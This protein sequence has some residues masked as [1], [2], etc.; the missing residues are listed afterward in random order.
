MV[1][2]WVYW[3][4][5]P[6]LGEWSLI[7][8]WYFLIL[9]VGL[10]R[11]TVWIPRLDDRPAI[12]LLWQ[13]CEL[14]TFP[15]AS[16]NQRQ[17][18]RNH[19]YSFSRNS[20][21]H[22]V[23][24]FYRTPWC[25]VLV[26]IVRSILHTGKKKT[27]RSLAFGSFLGQPWYISRNPGPEPGPKFESIAMQSETWGEQWITHLTTR[28][29]IYWKDRWGFGWAP[30]KG[31]NL[32]DIKDCTER[33]DILCRNFKPRNM[34]RRAAQLLEKDP[35]QTSKLPQTCLNLRMYYVCI[36]ENRQIWFRVISARIV[37]LAGA[38]S[39]ALAWRKTT[40]GAGREVWF[41]I[42]IVITCYHT[43][44][45]SSHGSHGYFW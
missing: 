16:L 37:L 28:N 33:L 40:P 18:A 27:L 26:K 30:Q 13:K 42:C 20:S 32:L 1:K 35:K 45:T 43:F 8:F 9:L 39:C 23:F 38:T 41:L 12:F 17:E 22:T 6:I 14:V 4:I 34:P 2:T 21:G 19:T 10:C 7:H 36:K 25:F 3:C 11:T 44:Y 31:W 5:V 24:A 29:G 15:D